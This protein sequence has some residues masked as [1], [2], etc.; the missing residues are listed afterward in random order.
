MVEFNTFVT[1]LSNQGNHE[2][3]RVKYT[4]ILLAHI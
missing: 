1:C 2:A 3:F 4:H